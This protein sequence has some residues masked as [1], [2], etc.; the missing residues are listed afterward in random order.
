MGVSLKGKRQGHPKRA[1]T[2]SRRS[3][4]SEMSK[5][6]LPRLS[7][8]NS[9]RRNSPTETLTSRLSR[10]DSP[11]ETLRSRLSHQ[12]SQ[13]ET[14]PLKVP[15]RDSPTKTLPPRLSH[16]D[17]HSETL[18]LKL[19]SRLSFRDSPTETPSSS[20]SFRDSPCPKTLLSRLSLPANQL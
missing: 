3:S 19:P 10:R 12:D 7:R 4:P 2:L 15:L 11:V 13:S 5:F 6:F 8:L 1:P 20:L 14:L 17:S 16:Q 9:F 18:P